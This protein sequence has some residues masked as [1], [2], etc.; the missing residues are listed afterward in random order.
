MPRSAEAV[1]DTFLGQAET[2]LGAGHS[3]VLYG[4]LARGD[5]LPGRSDVNLLVV[6]RP[7]DEKGLRALG[8]ALG[9]VEIAGLAPPLLFDEAEWKRCADVFPIEIT[10]MLGGYRVLRGPDPLAGVTVVPSDLR[11][12][13]EHEWRG[14]VLRLRQGFAA[15][16]S[17]AD[18]LGETM[19]RVAGSVR[20]LLR[21]TVALGGGTA[22]LDDESLLQELASRAG[23][24]PAP[25]AEPLARRRLG[26]AECD[27][28]SFARFLAAVEQVTRYVDSFHAGEQ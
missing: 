18:L 19:L 11:R 6:G 17:R 2:A 14:L 28:A 27:E 13:L 23:L 15:H 21:T 20:V 16:P 4:S 26:G 24:D 5:F 7:L 25:F 22:A 12:A 8:P 9:G 3:I 1:L 10:D